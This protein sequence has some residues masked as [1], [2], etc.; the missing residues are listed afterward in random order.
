MNN[1]FDIPS[2]N[3]CNY[4]YSSGG[5]STNLRGVIVD[6][7]RFYGISPN[8]QMPTGWL[9]NVPSYTGGGLVTGEYTYLRGGTSSNATGYYSTIGNAMGYS[10]G[11]IGNSLYESQLKDLIKQ[12]ILEEMKPSGLLNRCVP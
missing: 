4:I 11:I 2:G 12:I 10:R 7:H 6:N 9:N 5:N 8:S 3:P 1:T